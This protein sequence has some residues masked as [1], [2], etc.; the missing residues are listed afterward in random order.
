MRYLGI[1][2]NNYSIYSCKIK[3][4]LTVYDAY[5]KILKEKNGSHMFLF[6]GFPVTIVRSFIANGSIFYGYEIGL[7]IYDKIH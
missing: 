2:F 7:Q 1:Q 6:R 3:I 4:L 5:K